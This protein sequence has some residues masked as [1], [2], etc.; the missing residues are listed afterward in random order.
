MALTDTVIRKAKTGY[1]PICRLM[2]WSAAFHL[3]TGDPG[4]RI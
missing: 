3:K 1:V 4:G 2:R